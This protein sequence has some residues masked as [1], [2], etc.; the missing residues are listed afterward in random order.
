MVGQRRKIN[1]LIISLGLSKQCRFNNNL[2]LSAVTKA[3]AVLNLTSNEI[4][5]IIWF[6]S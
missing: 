4:K 3:K 1:K 2:N 6:E 5:L